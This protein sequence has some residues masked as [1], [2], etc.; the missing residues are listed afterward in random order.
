MTCYSCP[1]N[2]IIHMIKHDLSILQIPYKLHSC[3]EVDSTL[4]TI[5]RHLE[6]KH[7]L[8]MNLSW[9]VP[10]LDVVTPTLGFQF[11]DAIN[12]TTS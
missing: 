12:V 7:L 10:F 6:N 9:E 4:D 8:S 5:C 3:D 11:K 2:N 1:T